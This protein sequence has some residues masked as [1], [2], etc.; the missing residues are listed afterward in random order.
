MT[1]A[2]RVSRPPGARTR[3]QRGLTC[4]TNLNQGYSLRREVGMRA[5]TVASIIVCAG[6]VGPHRLSGQDVPPS[7]REQAKA[8]LSERQIKESPSEFAIYLMDAS[9]RNLAVIRTLLLAGVSPKLPTVDDRLYPLT[10][11]GGRARAPSRQRQPRKRC[12]RRAPI[13]IRRRRLTAAS[14]R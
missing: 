9:E 4:D 3:V 12:W 2:Q 8:W 11:L 10:V 7:S 14:R 5:L 1:A 13:R 6:L